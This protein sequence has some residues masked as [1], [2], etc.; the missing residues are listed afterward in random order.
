ML[1]R[2]CIF[3]NREIIVYENILKTFIYEESGGYHPPTL[4]QVR[5]PVVSNSVCNG[6]YSSVSII[7]SQMC[8]GDTIVGGVDSCQVSNLSHEK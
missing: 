6:L 3:R 8:A 2:K 1:K 4:N 5:L 7:E